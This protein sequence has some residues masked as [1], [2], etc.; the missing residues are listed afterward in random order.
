MVI[1]YSSML[2]YIDCVWDANDALVQEVLESL[3]FAFSSL[4]NRIIVDRLPGGC[5][6]VAS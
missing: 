5:Y 1:R 4:L 6:N 3:F 2:I